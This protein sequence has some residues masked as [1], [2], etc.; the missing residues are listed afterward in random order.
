MGPLKIKV[1]LKKP[2]YSKVFRKNPKKFSGFDANCTMSGE[3]L[4]VASPPG[5][6]VLVNDVDIL[7]KTTWLQEM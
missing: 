4:R 2:I 5:G 7:Q 3:V 1:L 6:I